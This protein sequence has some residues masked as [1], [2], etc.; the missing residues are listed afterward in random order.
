MTADIPLGEGSSKEPTSVSFPIYFSGADPTVTS[1]LSQDEGLQRDM[2]NISITLA[3]ITEQ[4]LRT[5]KLIA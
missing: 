5:S 1:D 3:R 4:D 2:W